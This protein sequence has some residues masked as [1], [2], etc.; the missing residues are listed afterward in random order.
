MCTQGFCCNV[1]IMNQYLLHEQFSSQENH[2]IA[3]KVV[4]K[5]HKMMV[6]ICI[7][8]NTTVHHFNPFI[9]PRVCCALVFPTMPQ[10]RMRGSSIWKKRSSILEKRFRTTRFNYFV[11]MF[12]SSFY[13][14]SWVVRC[15]QGCFIF[16]FIVALMMQNTWGHTHCT[17]CQ[18]LELTPK[19][20]G[21][22]LATYP[23]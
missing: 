22:M 3:F 13:V 10:H 1:V 18:A 17:N 14:Y 21:H 11:G 4:T 15:P 2:T 23:S 19:S 16:H 5:K 12:L 8:N 20:N 7:F 9:H 6:Y